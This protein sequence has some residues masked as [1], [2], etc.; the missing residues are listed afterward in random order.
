MM[1]G[2]TG[3]DVSPEIRRHTNAPIFFLTAKTSDLD[4]LSGFAY[5]ADDYITKPFNPLELIAR[6]KAHLKE[7]IYIKKLQLLQ[8]LQPTNMNALYFIPTLRS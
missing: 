4:K 2:Q 1:P 6:I 5:G 3:F 8:Y 7:R